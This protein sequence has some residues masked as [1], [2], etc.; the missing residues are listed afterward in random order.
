MRNQDVFKQ[1]L[2]RQAL[3]N[4]YIKR[5][6]TEFAKV[7][8]KAD[9]KLVEVA[10]AAVDNIGNKSLI[11]KTGAKALDGVKDVLLMARKGTINP[12]IV[13]FLDELRGLIEDQTGFNRGLAEET[14]VGQE[15]GVNDPDPDKDF[16]LYPIDGRTY[17]EWWALFF[18]GDTD[19]LMGQVRMGLIAG[20]G[21]A[22]LL[23][24]LQASSR[25]T[26]NSLNSLVPT[27]IM[28]ALAFGNYT[29][30]DANPDL[31][32]KERYTAIMDSRTS[33]ICASLDGK[34]Y[35]VGE[36][37]HPPMHRNCR[38]S[39][40]PVYVGA[41]DTTDGSVTYEEWLKDQSTVTQNQ[42]LGK[43]KAMLF[44]EGNL[45]IADM[46]RKNGTPMTR[47]ELTKSSAKAR[48]LLK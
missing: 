23:A 43:S 39:R 41:G 18:A 44:R 45:S 8:D 17:D 28:G 25:T 42:V 30:M 7:L 33:M 10:I 4:R 9:R 46:L 22:D 48:E 20:E 3:V 1:F 40:V 38:S 37:P 36:G 21:E 35:K 2:V 15:Q 5:S 13:D 47:G 14:D 31:V 6:Q 16:L 29:F 27:A 12:I 34:I 19:R 32:K 24:R 26:A 11:T